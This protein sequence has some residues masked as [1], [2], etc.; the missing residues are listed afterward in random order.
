MSPEQGI[1]QINEA[2]WELMEGS[3]NL[4]VTDAQGRRVIA[5][6]TRR[7]HY[8]DR[9]HIQLN[10]DMPGAV[11]GVPELDA[12][13]SFPRYFFGFEEADRHTRAFLKWRI[14]KTRTAAAESIQG[15]WDN[16]GLRESM[17][18]IWNTGERA[19]MMMIN[20]GSRE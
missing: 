2:Q 14:W 17:L 10:I 11:P 9:G 4:F 15:F 19:E 3:L 13:D 20:R 5:W 16:P 7:P 6:L 18:E 8:C 1:K 12:A